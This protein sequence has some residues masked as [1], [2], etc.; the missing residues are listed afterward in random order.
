MVNVKMV[1]ASNIASDLE[2]EG[3]IAQRHPKEMCT[4]IS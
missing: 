2:M 1:G 3:F 4:V